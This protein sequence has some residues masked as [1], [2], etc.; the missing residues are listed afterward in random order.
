MALCMAQI[1]CGSAPTEHAGGGTHTG[2]PVVVACVKAAFDM[3]ETGNAWKLTRHLPPERLNPASIEPGAGAAGLMKA[4]VSVRAA[5]PTDTFAVVDTFY[6]YDTTVLVHRYVETDTI[7]LQTLVRDTVDTVAGGEPSRFITSYLVDSV[8]YVFDTLEQV[9]TIAKIDTLVV[10]RTYYLVDST[11]QSP[12]D[13]SASPVTGDPS[14]YE[15]D[16]D[17]KYSSPPSQVSRNVYPIGTSFDG[18][19]SARNVAAL[20]RSYRTSA[21]IA[22]SA[23]YGDGDGDGL[24]FSAHEGVV[25]LATLDERR[26]GTEGSTVV[27]TAMLGAGNDRSLRASGDNVLQSL[28]QVHLKGSDTTGIVTFLLNETSGEP[29]LRLI[30]RNPADSVVQVQRRYFLRDAGTAA[31][32]DGRLSA[33]RGTCDF[34]DSHKDIRQLEISLDNLAI[35]ATGTVASASFVV[36]CTTPRGTSAT[37]IGILDDSR[38]ITASFRHEGRQYEITARKGSDGRIEIEP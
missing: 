34:A 31:S 35:G 28:T 14:R 32:M 18:R 33:I 2:N 36:S 37:M 6:N 29:V 4:G 1:R 12:T 7:T 9:D 11:L 38:T 22:V 10:Y 15:G 23:S 27:N 3:S 20:N 26:I 16:I 13:E 24:L 5:A 21:G 30:D 17:R 19:E 8:H 25:P